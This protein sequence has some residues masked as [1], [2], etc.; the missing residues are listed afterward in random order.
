MYIKDLQKAADKH[1]P[2]LITDLPTDRPV[3]VGSGANPKLH[4]PHRDPVRFGTEPIYDKTTGKPNGHS[5]WVYEKDDSGQ[6]TRKEIPMQSA[7]SAAPAVTP[8]AAHKPASTNDG[9]LN[10]SK[11]AYGE[12]GLMEKYQFRQ[13]HPELKG[14]VY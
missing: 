13:K 1:A 12:L 6:W 8:A 10:A 5:H 7:P 2:P 4:E 9:D 3:A 11:K 14:K